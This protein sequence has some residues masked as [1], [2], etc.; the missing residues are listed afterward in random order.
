MPTSI[1]T[2]SLTAAAVERLSWADTARFMILLQRVRWLN[3]RIKA[4]NRR[5]DRDGFDVGGTKLALMVLRWLA[6]HEAIS[7]LLDCPEPLSVTI[8][9]ATLQPPNEIR[10]PAEA[11]RP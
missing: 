3:W 4:A 1:R 6:C 7:A 8:V 2:P 10:R 11:A 5:V 9:R